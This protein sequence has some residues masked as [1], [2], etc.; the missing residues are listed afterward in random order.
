MVSCRVGPG[1]CSA[2]ADVTRVLVVCGG[3]AGQAAYPS[4]FG[5]VV[6]VTDGAAPFDG[7]LVAQGCVFPI[8]PA[9]Q[10]QRSLLRASSSWDKTA[11]SAD[12]EEARTEGV[13][14]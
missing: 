8:T 1:L 14:I 12:V 3:R 2:R 9:N 7:S 13:N 4:K 11:T 6:R 10:T 5:E